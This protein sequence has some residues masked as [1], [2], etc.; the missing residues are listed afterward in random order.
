MPIQLD[1][2]LVARPTFSCNGRSRSATIP[3]QN[4]EG[5]GSYGQGAED[6]NFTHTRGRLPRV[7]PAGDPRGGASRRVARARLH[8]D[9]PLGLGYLGKY[10]AGARPAV[11][12]NRARERLLSA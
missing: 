11:Q 8:G 2:R 10:A 7:V 5:N 3:P 6:S 12:G 4:E 1:R 9:P